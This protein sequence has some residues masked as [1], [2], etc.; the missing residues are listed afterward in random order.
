M[1]ADIPRERLLAA[2]RD[3]NLRYLGYNVR[4]DRESASGKL[5][6]TS[7]IADEILDENRTCGFYF[8]LSLFLSL[9]HLAM[10]SQ[11]CD[12]THFRTASSRGMRDKNEPPLLCG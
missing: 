12:R 10:P 2:V 1:M 8:S 4:E 9:A 3:P 7:P 5:I 6:A 11:R